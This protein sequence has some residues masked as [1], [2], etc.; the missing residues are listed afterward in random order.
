MVGL[1]IIAAVTFCIAM[2]FIL[3]GAGVLNVIKYIFNIELL[4]E[5]NS[6]EKPSRKYDILFWIICFIIAL[7]LV[8]VFKK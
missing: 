1:L 5:R 4:K 3:F 8:N 6:Q 2:F 7:V